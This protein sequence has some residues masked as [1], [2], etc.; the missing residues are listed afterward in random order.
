M[1]N[2][3]RDNEIVTISQLQVALGAG[4]T[5]IQSELSEV[6]LKADTETIA[7]LFHLLQ[8]VTE[9]LGQN[10]VHWTHVRGNSQTL[11][12]REEAEAVFEQISM[13]ERSK[14]SAETLSNVEGKIVQKD[15]PSPTDPGEAAYVVVTLL[16]GTADDRPL[17]GNI[18]SAAATREAL[19]RLK[20]IQP[21][22]LMIF[23]MLWS[24]QA[25][26]DTLTER[27]MATEY[28]DMMAIA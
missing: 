16:V 20:S 3:E 26:T 2:H 12:S 8:E 1:N 19:D 21:D 23:E 28:G 27:E 4:V 9:I 10:S 13:Q 6:S 18:N 7:G 17:F 24:P 25:E 5:S 22:Y 15:V 14:F 11:P